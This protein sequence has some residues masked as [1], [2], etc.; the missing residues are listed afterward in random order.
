VDFGTLATKAELDALSAKAD[1]S[2]SKAEL[3]ETELRL[4][5][6]LESVKTDLLKWVIGAMG[7]QTLVILGALV[8]FARMAPR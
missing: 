7:F 2:A 4:E 1:L 3:R 8:S 6:R 5:A